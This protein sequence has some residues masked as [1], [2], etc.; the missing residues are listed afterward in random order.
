MLLRTCFMSCLI[1]G[2]IACAPKTR[3]SIQDIQDRADQAAAAQSS[4]VTY[5]AALADK[6]GADDYGMRSYVFV[7]LK[8]GPNDALITDEA[9]RAELFK[10]HFA[11]MSRLAE[12]GKLVLGGPFV[13]AAP[14]RGLFIFNVPTIEDAKALTQTDPAFAA[15]IFTADYDKYYGSAALMQINDVHKTLQ[16]PK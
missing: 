5:D 13:D 10:G 2:L 16:K 9:K 3:D 8:T 15:G 14:K 1:T 6:L 7:T 11:N 12:D 4:A